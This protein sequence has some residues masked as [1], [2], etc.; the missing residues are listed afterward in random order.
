MRKILFLYGPVALGILVSM[1]GQIA[2]LEFKSSLSG[3]GRYSDMQ[4]AT[5]LVQFPVGIVVAALGLAVL[6]MI[7]SDAAGERLGEF[8]D[9]LGLGFRV[10]LVL[11]VPAALGLMLLGGP[12]ASVI[13]PPRSRSRVRLRSD[14][15]CATGLR[16]AAP[17]YR[18]RP[19]ADLCLLCAP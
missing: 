3:T 5:T 13:F 16:A 7:S 10:V 8:K 15:D 19:T 2:D 12:I 17:L 14:S 9:K 18:N 6:P 4:Y 11:M 1:A